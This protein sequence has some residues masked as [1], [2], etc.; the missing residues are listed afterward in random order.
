MELMFKTNNK[1]RLEE[2]YEID[3]IFDLEEQEL[4]ITNKEND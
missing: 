2:L 4:I 1:A 3:Y